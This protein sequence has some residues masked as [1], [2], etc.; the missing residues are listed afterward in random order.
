MCAS[1]HSNYYFKVLGI[2]GVPGKL[3]LMPGNSLHFLN[4]IFKSCKCL[5][6]V[7]ILNTMFNSSLSSTPFPGFRTAFVACSM[8]S[9]GEAWEMKLA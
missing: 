4:S 3:Y 8:K 1:L 5:C 2:P 9:A 7:L 6:V